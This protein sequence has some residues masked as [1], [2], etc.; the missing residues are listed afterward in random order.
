MN[1]DKVETLDAGQLLVVQS[2]VRVIILSGVPAE[3]WL[4]ALRDALVKHQER[5]RQ[6]TPWEPEK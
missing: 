2:W 6:R 5:D 1:A 3:L 4:E